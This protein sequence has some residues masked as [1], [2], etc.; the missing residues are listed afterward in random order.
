M[1]RLRVPWLVVLSSLLMGC[2]LFPL[3]FTA[4]S[5]ER[6]CPA[7][8]LCHPDTATCES[9]P[10]SL[11]LGSGVTADMSGDMAS[12]PPPGMILVPG[13]QFVM[14]DDSSTQMD[15]KPAHQQM[16]LPFYM[17][18]TLVTAADFLACM[19][20]GKCTSS[21]GTGVQCTHGVLGK[22]N[23]PINCVTLAQA[24]EYCNSNGKRLPT[25]IEFEYVVRGPAGA[26]YA[27]G[28]ENPSTQ[29]CWNQTETCPVKT[30]PATLFGAQ[31]LDGI[32]DLAGN[33]WEWL[34]SKKCN[35]PLMADG[36][37]NCDVAG[38]Q[39]PA[40]GSHFAENSASSLRGAERLLSDRNTGRADV[41]FRCAKSIQ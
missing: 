39:V 5:Q 2:S 3:R 16:M 11:D 31:R 23:H 41:G 36:G 12:P 34:D 18:I 10:P 14:G 6:P 1:T 22:E 24:R 13:G 33:T 35:Y 8:Q 40:R 17:D 20:N 9:A 30:Y 32:Y 27:W 4:C 7:G 29:L 19:T 37:V 28:N 38:T 15:E 21:P 25:E 26:T